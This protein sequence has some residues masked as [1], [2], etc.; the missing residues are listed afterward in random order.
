MTLNGTGQC[1]ELE[2]IYEV[3]EMHRPET[4]SEPIRVWQVKIWM[5]LYLPNIAEV[6]LFVEGIFGAEN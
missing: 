5:R 1:Q 6:V 4:V 2:H 3:V